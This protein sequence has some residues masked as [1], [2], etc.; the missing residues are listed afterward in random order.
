MH[1]TFNL[2][3][4]QACKHI[5]SVRGGVAHTL[6]GVVPVT[7]SLSRVRPVVCSSLSH[8]LSCLLVLST[9]LVPHCCQ[10]M[11]ANSVSVVCFV[12]VCVCSMCVGVG[13]RGSSSVVYIS[14]W[15]TR[16]N[17]ALLLGATLVSDM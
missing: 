7:S 13:E 8:K 9:Q 17:W 16:R 11:R 14:G 3:S 15:V 5:L 2:T 10:A 6:V 12:Y 1:G 4:S